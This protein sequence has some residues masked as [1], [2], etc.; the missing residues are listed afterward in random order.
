VVHQRLYGAEQPAAVA[1][2]NGAVLL[3]YRQKAE[4][5]SFD[6]AMRIGAIEFPPFSRHLGSRFF[7]GTSGKVHALSFD[8]AG[9]H[10]VDVP[11]PPS[12]MAVFCPIGR[13]GPAGLYADGAIRDSLGNTL[14]DPSVWSN[15]IMRYSHQIS[16]DGNR[17]VVSIPTP[18][19]TKNLGIDLQQPKPAWVPMKDLNSRRFLLGERADLCIDS[20]VQLRRNMQGI[21]VIDGDLTLI[22]GR[23]KQLSLQSRIGKLVYAG[24]YTGSGTHRPFKPLD[25]DD[26]LAHGLHLATWPD[27]SC[28]WMDPRGILH[29]RNS[30]LLALEISILLYESDGPITAWTSDGRTYGTGHMLEAP[31]TGKLDDLQAHLRAFVT[32]I[33]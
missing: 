28:A 2:H 24:R 30:D 10:L 16:D 23:N 32:R 25:S 27:G 33:S 1:G 4:A 8:G 18:E 15:T 7:E 22:S 31:P 12:P 5:Y 6:R 26:G 17:L 20:S 29:L 21:C 9:L 3:I 11:L 13:D 19:G 14:V